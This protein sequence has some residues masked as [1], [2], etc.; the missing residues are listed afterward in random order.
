LE[1]LNASFESKKVR[2]ECAGE[3][4]WLFKTTARQVPM[5]AL[6]ACVLGDDIGCDVASFMGYDDLET[7]SELSAGALDA[8]DAPHGKHVVASM[9]TPLQASGVS[10]RAAFV[11]EDEVSVPTPNGS[12]PSYS[13]A[14]SDTTSEASDVDTDTWWL[15]PP[16]ADCLEFEDP[17][18]A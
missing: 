5:V 18:G 4:L 15:S 16:H 13:V 1:Q 8:C 11:F 14:G 7:S 17:V 2:P 6:A 3:W 10:G 12:L 9:Y